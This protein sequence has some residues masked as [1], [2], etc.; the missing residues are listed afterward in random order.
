MYMWTPVVLVDLV[1]CISWGAS[2]ELLF[3]SMGVYLWEFIG[4]SVMT[5]LTS[6]SWWGG[7]H[8]EFQ[9]CLTWF[10]LSSIDQTS[11]TAAGQSGPSRDT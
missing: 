10:T 4:Q 2:P 3:S 7:F 1:V 6:L 8:Q 9:Q 11:I 5:G